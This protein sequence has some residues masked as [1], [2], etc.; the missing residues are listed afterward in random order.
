[1]LALLHPG[2][3]VDL[4]PLLYQPADFEEEGASASPGGSDKA[5]QTPSVLDALHKLSQ[6]CHVFKKSA[7]HLGQCHLSVQ[8]LCVSVNHMT[9]RAEFMP[10]IAR[11]KSNNCSVNIAYQSKVGVE[12]IRACP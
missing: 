8:R 3:S 2:S 5:A 1:M 4:A 9:T 6:Q 10:A 12:Q 11:L 7:E